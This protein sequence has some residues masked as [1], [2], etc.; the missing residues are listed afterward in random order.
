MGL[1]AN[2]ITLAAVFIVFA[3]IWRTYEKAGQPGWGCLIPIYSW[4]VR[5]EMAERPGWWLIL[6]LIPPVNIVILIIVS[7][8]IAERFGHGT[9]FGFGLAL[10]APIF[11]P[12]LGFGEAEYL[13]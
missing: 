8:D 5:L 7:I 13:A 9:V 4:Y 10:L 11:Y 1:T 2:S 12:I 3:G 6:M